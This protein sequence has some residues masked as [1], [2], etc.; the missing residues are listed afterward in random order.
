VI[1]L[2]FATSTAL[3]TGIAWR[4]AQI[5][6]RWRGTTL[7]ALPLPLPLVTAAVAASAC[8]RT[9]VSPAL[10]AAIAVVGVAAVADA[11]SGRIVDALTLT[12]LAVAS[13]DALVRG[14]LGLA[15]GGAAGTGGALLLL[16]VV[17]RRRGIGLGDV[18]LAAGLGA[19]LGAPLGMTALGVAFVVGGVYATFLVATRRA[20]RGRRVCFAPF[21]AVG[22]YTALLSPLA[23]AP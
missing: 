4:T 23:P 22:T 3:A 6:A 10:I 9:S 21:I 5:G 7:G 20:Q 12:L 8:A 19:A 14:T 1:A 16:Y 11:R 13:V 17:T 15:L 18:K 2:L